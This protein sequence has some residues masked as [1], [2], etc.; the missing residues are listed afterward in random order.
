[1]TNPPRNIVGLSHALCCEFFGDKK[2]AAAV[3]AT[4]GGGRDALFMTRFLD[5]NK[6]GIG[7][8]DWNKDGLGVENK[9]KNKKIFGFDVQKAAVERSRALFEENGLSDIAEF[10]EVGHERMLEFI[11]P[12]FF[13]KIGCVFFNLG[14]LPDSDKTRITKPETTLAALKCAL[15]I[16]DKNRAFLSVASYRGHAGGA[17]EF[18]AVRGFFAE[19]FGEKFESYGDVGNPIAPV[20]FIARF[21]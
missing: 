10:F 6:S 2:I 17:E 12:E 21:A 19:N 1:M 5:G 18:D 9:N 14:W 20:L 15:R 13:G 16:I 11:P 8:G 3:D 7:N 4:L